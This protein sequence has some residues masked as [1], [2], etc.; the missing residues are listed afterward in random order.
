MSDTEP[1]DIEQPTPVASGQL[2]LTEQVF[3]QFKS[4]L[5]Q[6]VSNLTTNLTAKADSRSKR[7]ER[8]TTGQQLKLA[9]NK[10]Q[11]LFNAELQNSIKESTELLQHQ[12]VEGALVKLETAQQSLHL[13][14]K[15]IKL[16]DKS[17]AGWLA[18]KEYKAEDL[19]SDSDDEKR[20]KKAQA[21]AVRKK[22]KSRQAKPI[23]QAS[24][25]EFVN[26]FP[27][28][29][30]NQLFR[31]N[32]CMATIGISLYAVA[33]LMQPTPVSGVENE[34]LGPKP[35][36]SSTGK[37][38]VCIPSSPPRVPTLG[39][40]L[41]TDLKPEIVVNDYFGEELE[42][43]EQVDHLDYE[44][45][46]EFLD[47][48]EPVNAV[49]LPNVKGRLKSHL[50]FWTDIKAPDF[51]IECIREGYKIP[52]YSTPEPATFPNNRSA[53]VHTDFVSEALSELLSTCRVVET[54]NI[55]LDLQWIPRTLN[56]QA[57]YVSKLND[58][59]DWEVVPGVFEQIDAQLRPHTLDCFANSKNAKVSRYF[60][61]F[62]N[63]GT[64]GVDTFYQDW[65]HEIAWVVPPISILSRGF[66]GSCL[67][68]NELANATTWGDFPV[69]DRKVLIRQVLRSRASSTVK[70]YV[71][72]HRKYISFLVHTRRPT[73]IP[74]D[75]LHIASYLAS[76]S[77]IKN[78]YNAVLQAFCGIK[79]VH[80]LLPTDVKG[81]P[82]DT[83]QS[84]NIVEASRRAFT[85][86][87]TKKEPISTL[88]IITVCQQFAGPSCTLKG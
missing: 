13:R 29:S 75:K 9:G 74:S 8:Q 11:F 33:F 39:S 50:A 83:T 48:H 81:N 80:S 51:I 25:N 31:G 30:D 10:D 72:E 70:K 27:V 6:K 5:D 24:R 32:S 16:A 37:D 42:R 54:P 26:R 14:Q 59:D 76:V 47:R 56:E 73:T 23:N 17:D 3:E 69:E 57:D 38:R 84:A 35:L 87:S 53:H 77:Q 4:Y 34:G 58:F 15:K 63:P 1:T 68:I 7:V 88:T 55:Q 67:R 36:T 40:L 12:D 71:R 61:R 49:G 19:A 79:W 2:N 44:Y 65:S 22:A 43:V 45:I 85:K 21:S 46:F 52:F 66:F 28:H 82:A 78:S 41:D 86:P 18:V 62:W 60:S 20:I 64:T